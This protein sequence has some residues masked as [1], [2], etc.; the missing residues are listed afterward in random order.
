MEGFDITANTVKTNATFDGT[1]LALWGMVESAVAVVIGLCPSFVLLIR[2]TRKSGKKAYNNGG[3]LKHDGANFNL[4]TIG[5]ISTQSQNK[6]LSSDNIDTFW[7]EVHS[8][9]EELAGEHK[10]EGIRVSTTMQQPEGPR[11]SN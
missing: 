9:Q 6:K 11:T 1:W 2:T 8:S 5:G 4:Q 10:K 7:T 3:Y